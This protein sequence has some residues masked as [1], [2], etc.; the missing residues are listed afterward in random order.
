MLVPENFKCL[1]EN[2]TIKFVIVSASSNGT[3]D[4]IAKNNI[5]N[6]YA[7]GIEDV[8]IKITLNFVKPRKIFNRTPREI[9]A[10]IL[11][12]LNKNNLKIGKIWLDVAGDAG[13]NN[14][15]TTYRWYE[16]KERNIKFIEVYIKI[17]VKRPFEIFFS[18]KKN[19]K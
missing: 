17:S 4:D 3:I 5:K 14:A 9:I 6:A 13:M 2:F 12:E 16:D 8:D 10:S 19:K 18:F 15:N 1:K 11:N 7:A